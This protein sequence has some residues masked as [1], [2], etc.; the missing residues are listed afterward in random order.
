MIDI[1]EIQK[2]GDT[3]EEDRR[4]MSQNPIQKNMWHNHMAWRRYDDWKDDDR[5]GV[6]VGLCWDP[7]SRQ[8]EIS[9]LPGEYSEGKKQGWGC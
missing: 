8:D 2:R 6:S 5:N 9:P 4:G 3:E 7:L 1:G